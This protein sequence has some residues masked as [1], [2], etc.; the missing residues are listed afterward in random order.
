MKNILV[1]TDFSHDAYNA[2]SYCTR[3][4]AS[5][6]C[7]FHILNVF[8][9]LTPLRGKST[10]LFTTKKLLKQLESQSTDQLTQTL[11]KINLDN[12][13]PLH[14]FETHSRQGK[15]VQELEKAIGELQI[16]LLV[17]GSKGQTGAREIFL[18]GNTIQ[19]AHTIDRCPTLA[20]PRQ[21]EFAVP[22]EFAFV[23]DFKKGC[24]RETVSPLLFLASLSEGAIRV[25]H[26]S[27][28]E[29]LDARQESNR[30][31][32]EH[33]LKDREVSFHRV[34]EYT[35]KARVIN[36]YLDKHHIDMLAMVQHRHGFLESLVREPVI[37]DLSMYADIPLLILPVH[38]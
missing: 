12:G 3:L 35:H 27:E 23:T 17:M 29:K 37:K 7:S 31:L 4:M 32:L 20:I 36:D 22:K 28:E 9:A 8:D 6:P 24:A 30:K 2:L 18:G 25:M 38:D 13:N 5:R 19:A 14:R 1:A 34:E 21:I 26:I 16:D 11:H 10:K 33:C 15:F